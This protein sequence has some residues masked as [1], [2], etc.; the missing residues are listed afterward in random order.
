MAEDCSPTLYRAVGGVTD[1]VLR[2][3]D[4]SDADNVWAVG[5]APYFDEE[6][7]LVLRWDGR[8][9]SRIASPSDIWYYQ[10]VAV[11]GSDDVWAVGRTGKSFGEARVTHWDGD[12]W[13]E[14]PFP[15]AEEAQTT[16]VAATAPDEVWVGGGKG[17]FEVEPHLAHWDGESWTAVDLTEHAPIGL[18]RALGAVAS[19]DVWAIVSIPD[20]ANEDELTSLVVH[21]DGSEWTPIPL[22]APDELYS[23]SA[24]N[25]NE[26]WVASSKALHRWNGRR[27]TKVKLPLAG[28]YVYELD[29][30][31]GST[32][33]A[34]NDLDHREVVARYDGSTWTHSALPDP[35]LGPD[36]RGLAVVSGGGAWSVGARH[37]HPVHAPA[38]QLSC[39]DL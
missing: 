33:I 4:L 30:A 32:W 8:A 18:V 39:L 16:S 27:W 15:A 14:P 25:P 19:D 3:V 9:W 23:L 34:G 35:T 5:G 2:D 29:Q 36:H 20:E 22:P 10:A 37:Q 12:A 11:L 28:M 17:I 24:V 21:W 31:D 6:S 26:L 7:S 1:G 13:T 38:T